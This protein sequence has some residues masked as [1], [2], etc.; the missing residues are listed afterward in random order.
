MNQIILK[1]DEYLLSNLNNKKILY[2]RFKGNILNEIDE[3]KKGDGTPFRVFTPFWRNA[4]KFYIEKI[5]PKEK[6]IKKCKR[7]I[8]YFKNCIEPEKILPKKIGLKILK[9]LGFLMNKML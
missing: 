1:F 8:S 7:K 2:K 4:E 6:E 5:P 9:K 3:V